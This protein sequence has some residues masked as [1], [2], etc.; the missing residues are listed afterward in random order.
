ML[1]TYLGQFVRSHLQEAF[2]EVD[3]KVAEVP[4]EVLHMMIFMDQLCAYSSIPRSTV[5][6]FIPPYIFDSL[7]LN[8]AS[9]K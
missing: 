2:H 4:K 8:M 1:F 6:K 3:N 9:K 5:Y 7:K